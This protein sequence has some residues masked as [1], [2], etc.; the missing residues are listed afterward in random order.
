MSPLRARGSAIV[1]I[2]VVAVCAFVAAG[3]SVIT[4]SGAS[5]AGSNEVTTWNQIAVSTLVGLPPP[6]GGAPPAAQ[7][8]MGMTQGAVYDAVNAIEPR[9]YQPYLLERRFPATASKDAAVATAAYKVLSNVVSSVPDRISFPTKADV[10]QTLASQYDASL[11]AIPDSRS[12]SQGIEAGN[13]AADAMIAARQNDGRFGP[14]QWV[15]NSDPGHWQPLVNPTTGQPILDPA[16]WVG[17]VKPFLMQSSSQFRTPGPNA[18]SSAAWAK[19]YNEVKALGSVNSTVRTAE[20]THIALFWQSTPVLTWN[21]VARDLIAGSKRGVGIRDTARLLAMANL[22]AADAAINAW[23]D[24]YYWDFWRPWNAI[25]RAA[26]DGNRATE[27]DP[28]W[29]ALITAPYPDHPSGH[30][31]LDGAYIG[32]FRMFFG[33]DEIRFSVPSLAF[34][35][36]TRSFDRFSAAL[37]EITEARIW[38]GLHYRTADVQANQLGANVARYM[39]EHFF[40]RIGN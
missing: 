3:A 2:L 22:T 26:E 25:A 19:D 12:K 40:Q 39:A 11:G 21:S 38:A 17:G 30:L 4:A 32:V 1:G 37:A 29:A 35:G 14:S 31:S 5:T 10:L 36:E 7:I 18:L 28:A 16:A 24:K 27:P 23:N 9:Q 34:P 15:P 6:A 13:A 20:Q 33:T 8:S